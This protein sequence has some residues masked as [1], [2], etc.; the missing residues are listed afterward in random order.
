MFIVT[1]NFN[2]I[3]SIFISKL[4]QYIIYSNLLLYDLILKIIKSNKYE[5]NKI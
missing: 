4:L 2:Y 3:N 5:N 1:S